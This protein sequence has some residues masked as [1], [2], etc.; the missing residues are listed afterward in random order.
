MIDLKTLQMLHMHGDRPVP[1]EHRPHDA[2]E[3]DPEREWVKHG[4]VYACDCGERV[5]V[6]P[7]HV[8]LPGWAPGPDVP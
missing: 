3:I 5:T 8:N 6:L 7:E 1:M 2:A 4:E